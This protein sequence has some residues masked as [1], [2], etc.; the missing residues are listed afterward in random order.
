MSRNEHAVSEVGQNG[1]QKGYA[2][3]H[4]NKTDLGEY[5]LQFHALYRRFVF[6]CQFWQILKQVSHSPIDSM[7]TFMHSYDVRSSVK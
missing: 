5:L 1:N 2:A 7:F 4:G 6:L 3:V